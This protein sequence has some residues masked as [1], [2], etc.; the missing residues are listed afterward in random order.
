MDTLLTLA[1]K[2]D[3]RVQVDV[4]PKTGVVV[5]VTNSRAA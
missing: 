4:G 1:R 3:L 2:L 5:K